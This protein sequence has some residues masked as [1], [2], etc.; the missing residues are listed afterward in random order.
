MLEA[1]CL[2]ILGLDPGAS[3]EDVK[4]AYR[5]LAK[6]NH[7]DRFTDPEEK[8]EHEKK[9]ARINEA[10]RILIGNGGAED[11]ILPQTFDDRA[12]YGKGLEFYN[13]CFK[14][15]YE[16]FERLE[17]QPVKEREENLR[18]AGDFFNLLLK[19]YP[20]SDWAYDA[21]KKLAELNKIEKTIDN[22]NKTM[23]YYKDKIKKG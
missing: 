18:K 23:R 19:Q 20:D 11:D 15:T 1:E 2:S 4:K 3:P 14:D 5:Q 17:K 13:R 9:M 6:K 8:S 16:R 7:P 10:Y 21:E 22:M 12:I